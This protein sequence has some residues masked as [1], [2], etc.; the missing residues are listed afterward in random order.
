MFFKRMVE[1]MKAQEDAVKERIESLFKEYIGLESKVDKE[2][3][4]ASRGDGL[5]VVGGVAHIGRGV[6]EA[7]QDGDGEQH[8]TRGQ[9]HVLPEEGAFHDSVRSNL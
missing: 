1:E 6:R 3:T 7:G 9:K 8:H 4:D 5:G 2:E